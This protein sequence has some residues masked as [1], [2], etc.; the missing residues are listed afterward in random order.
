M[1]RASTVEKQTP[2]QG[3]EEANIPKSHWELSNAN[4]SFLTTPC[5]G[6]QVSMPWLLTI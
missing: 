3:L 2:K 6:T 5:W 4:G 1:D